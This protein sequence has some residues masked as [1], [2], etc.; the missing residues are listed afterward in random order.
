VKYETPVFA[1]FTASTS[2]GEDDVIDGS[3]RY[4]GEI[5]GFK[6]AFAAGYA[7]WLDTTR[8]CA[9]LG[10]G[11][12][13]AVDCDELGLSGSIMHLQSGLFATGAYGHRQD[14]NLVALY[15]NAAGVDDTSEF[16]SVQA[17]IE[18]KWFDVGKTTI[19]GEYWEENNG[20]GLATNGGKLNATPLGAGAFMSGSEITVW[21]AGVNQTLAEGVD[22]YLSYRHVETDVFTS[23]NG[24]RAGAAKVSIEPFQYLTIGSQIKF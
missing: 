5:G 6:M 21:G 24:A 19:F 18:K 23:A 8:G 15:G 10:A 16:F 2:W 4:S 13:S 7:H 11:K 3:L 14:N 12:S 17:G 22:L 9:N 20:A 1:G